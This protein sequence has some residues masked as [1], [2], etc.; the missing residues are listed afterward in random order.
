MLVQLYYPR[1]LSPSR[2]DKYLAGGWFRSSSLLF[3]TSLICLEE[4]V[5]SVINI[6]LLLEDFAFKKRLRKIANRNAKKFQYSIGKPHITEAKERLYQQHKSRF[7][8][9]VLESLETFLYANDFGPS[10]FDTYEISVYDGDKLVAVSYF[11]LGKESM[12]SILGLYD[13]DYEKYSPG[14]YTMLLEVEEALRRGVKYY[15]PGYILDGNSIFDYK[16]RLG[17][18]QF[19]NWKGR[20]QSFSNYQGED[21]DANRLKV[22]VETMAKALDANN[23][24][25]ERLLY[26]YFSAGHLNLFEFDLLKSPLF[27]SCYPSEELNNFMAVEYDFKQ[28]VYKVSFVRPNFQLRQMYFDTPFYHQETPSQSVYAKEILEYTQQVWI[29][30]DPNLLAER[31]AEVGEKRWQMYLNS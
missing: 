5:Y 16:L 11:D 18:Y 17:T 24:P 13:K 1:S 22:G 31:I 2:L 28:N 21:L 27:I 10:V 8:G 26:P 25:Y 23:I 30:D 15:Y 4:D 19:Y 29:V 7:K 3:R 20:W 6:R 9:F 12:A 14:T